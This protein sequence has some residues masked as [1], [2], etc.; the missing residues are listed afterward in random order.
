M[1]GLRPIELSPRLTALAQQVP[2][3]ARFADIGTDHARLPVWLLEHG[4]IS[5][6]IAADL[7]SGPLDRARET[8]RRHNVSERIS[9]RFGDGLQPI[10]PDEADVIAI[11]GM[12]GETISDILLAAPWVAERDILLLLQPMTSAP[13]LREW[14]SGHCFRI[15]GERLVQEEENLYV[16]LTVRPGRMPELSRAE[17][18]AG[19]QERGMEEPLRGDYLALMI[20]RV[21]H[22]ADGLRRSTRIEDAARLAEQA[23]LLRELE[24]MKEEWDTWQM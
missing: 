20:G 15:C 11:A 3:N 5:R 16:I 13:K 21:K 18:W 12:G 23:T 2:E 24:H 6:A 4:V 19:C 7:R 8:A 14:L 1:F 22:A 10:Q 9:F 17:L